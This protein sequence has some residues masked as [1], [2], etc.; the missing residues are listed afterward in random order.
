MLR[1]N[2]GH[3]VENVVRAGVDHLHHDVGVEEVGGDHVRHEG[4]ILFLEYDSHDVVAYVSLSLQLQY[5]IAI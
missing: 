2:D 1:K 4:S 3:L 5:N